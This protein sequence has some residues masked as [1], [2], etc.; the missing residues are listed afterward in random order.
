[1][2]PYLK[3]T[4]EVHDIQP[5]MEIQPREPKPISPYLAFCKK[6]RPIIH[7]E[8]PTLRPS[9]ITKEIARRWR[10]QKPSTVFLKKIIINLLAVFTFCGVVYAGWNGLIFSP[11]LPT[12]QPVYPIISDAAVPTMNEAHLFITSTFG[13]IAIVLL[14][15][16]S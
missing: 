3:D 5:I 6:M 16:F 15:I 9:E 13:M 1:M 8:F 4:L 7:Q 11:H 2:P 10:S 12:Y 14:G